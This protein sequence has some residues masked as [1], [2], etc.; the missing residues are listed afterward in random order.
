MTDSHNRHADHATRSSRRY[1]T[2]F[3]TARNAAVIMP[4]HDSAV[5]GR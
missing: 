3:Y 2:L 5:T 1:Q 4:A